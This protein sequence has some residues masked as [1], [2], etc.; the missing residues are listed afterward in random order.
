MSFT[1]NDGTYSSSPANRSITIVMPTVAWTGGA[2]TSS[3]GDAANGNSDAV[4]ASFD[5]VVIDV[6]G[7]LTINHSAGNGHQI[8]TH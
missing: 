1:A 7:P 8:D 5:Q 2:G 6:P 4:P 3:W